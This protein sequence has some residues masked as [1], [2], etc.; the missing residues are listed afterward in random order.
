MRAEEWSVLTDGDQQALSS[1]EPQARSCSVPLQGERPFSILLYRQFRG[2]VRKTR[3][4]VI[5]AALTD[6]RLASV[7]VEY[8]VH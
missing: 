4:L 8:N 6:G 1:R 7:L 2:E 5:R 3:A